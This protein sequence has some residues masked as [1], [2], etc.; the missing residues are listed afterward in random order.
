MPVPTV[1][2]SKD[3]VALLIKLLREQHVTVLWK[4]RELKFLTSSTDIRRSSNAALR[5]Y[6]THR[7]RAINLILDKLQT[8]NKAMS[9]LLS[10]VTD[11]FYFIQSF[12]FLQKKKWII[13]CNR[14]LK[15]YY[16]LTTRTHLL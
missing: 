13:L 4:I 8:L 10:V 12:T 3:R 14:A 1:T 7:I 6:L 15:S 5:P 16:Y 11:E 9:I 2:V